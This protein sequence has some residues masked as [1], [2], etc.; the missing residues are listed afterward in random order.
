MNDDPITRAEH[1]EFVRRVED[2]NRRQNKRLERLEDD[3]KEIS[4]LTTSVAELA[5][6]MQ[7]MV[8]E[9]ERQRKCLEA[10]EGRDGD[11]WRKAIG[12]VVTAII[13]VIVGFIFSQ[14]GIV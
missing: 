7:T 9:Q 6:S 14:I 13:S 1:D 2:E 8:K 4:S 12:Y 3:A 11:M 5:L 10:L